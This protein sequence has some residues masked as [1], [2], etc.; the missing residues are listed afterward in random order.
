[1]A[2]KMRPSRVW[3]QAPRLCASIGIPEPGPQARIQR[4]DQ[5]GRSAVVAEIER[6]REVQLIRYRRRDSKI[7]ERPKVT[8]SAERWL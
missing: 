3:L 2:H 8:E 4:A 7:C 6:Y 1:M 5:V